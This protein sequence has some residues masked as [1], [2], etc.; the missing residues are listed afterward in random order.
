MAKKIIIGDIISSTS[1]NTLLIIQIYYRGSFDHGDYLD[2]VQV[3]I[4]D[5]VSAITLPTIDPDYYEKTVDTTFDMGQVDGTPTVQVRAHSTYD[6]WGE[7]S[8]PMVVPE[9]PVLLR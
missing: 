4:D 3:K 1:N 5:V 6:S 9:F 2:K 8:S 7:W